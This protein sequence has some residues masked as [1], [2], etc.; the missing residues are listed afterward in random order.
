MYH[1]YET[2]HGHELL[3]KWDCTSIGLH[4]FLITQ[5]ITSSRQLNVPLDSIGS[6]A[7]VSPPYFSVLSVMQC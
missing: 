1:G 6:E 5:A 4:K 3:M 2:G 7:S